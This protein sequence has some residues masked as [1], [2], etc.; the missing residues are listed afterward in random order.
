MQCLRYDAQAN[1]SS[2]F[3]SDDT[4]QPPQASQTISSVLTGSCLASLQIL[5]IPSANLHI[6]RI[7]VQALRE[8]FRIIFATLRTP[9]RTLVGVVVGL[10]CHGVV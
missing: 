1:A 6:S 10:A 5:Q 2:R 8:A 3:S 9:L 7:L 4:S